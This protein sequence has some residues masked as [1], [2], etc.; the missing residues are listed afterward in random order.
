MMNLYIYTRNG[1]GGGC[2]IRG[3]IVI[4]YIMYYYTIIRRAGQYKRFNQTF[5]R[6][7]FFTPNSPA[8]DFKITAGEFEKKVL[9]T[10]FSLF[11]YTNKI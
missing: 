3:I 10:F 11:F 5:K 1:N 8:C 6:Y 9:R 2:R 4:H 7:V